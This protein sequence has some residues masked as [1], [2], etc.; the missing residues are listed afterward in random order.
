MTSSRQ[1]T[2]MTGTETGT[3]TASCESIIS[4]AASSAPVRVSSCVT[5]KSI[6]F[7][8]ASST[9]PEGNVA[10]T[11]RLSKNSGCSR[12]SLV[13]SKNDVSTNELTSTSEATRGAARFA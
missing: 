13:F 3:M 6:E 12:G 1:S 7:A 8:I 10:R 4:R 9:S 11:L 2:T 5:T